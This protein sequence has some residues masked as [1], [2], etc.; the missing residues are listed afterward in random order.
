MLMQIVKPR[1]LK[2]T[3]REEIADM[4]LGSVRRSQL[5]APFGVGAMM[6][7]KNRDFCNMLRTRSL[8]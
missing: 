4:A 3:C 6:T 7:T 5:I 1:L 8:V 2:V